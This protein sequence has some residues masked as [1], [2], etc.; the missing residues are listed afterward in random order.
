ME[1]KYINYFQ[2]LFPKNKIIIL[3]FNPNTSSKLK[4]NRILVH[5]FKKI[6]DNYYQMNEKGNISYYNMNSI[7]IDKNIVDAIEKNNK[8]DR[9]MNIYLKIN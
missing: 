8:K 6:D 5:A 9:K 3:Y 2:K 1:E 7:K 4:E